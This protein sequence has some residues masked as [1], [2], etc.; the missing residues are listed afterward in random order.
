MSTPR[1][2]TGLSTV[3]VNLDEQIDRVVTMYNFVWCFEAFSLAYI[4]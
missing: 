3:I 4:I 1:G 2:P